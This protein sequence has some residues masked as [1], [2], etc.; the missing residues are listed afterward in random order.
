MPWSV[1]ICL[2][3]FIRYFVPKTAS[4]TFSASTPVVSLSP[5]FERILQSFFCLDALEQRVVSVLQC[6]EK[7][8]P[9]LEDVVPNRV[10]EGFPCGIHSH[11]INKRPRDIL[12]EKVVGFPS[13]QVDVE[14]E[15]ERAGREDLVLI[16]LG[17]R[18]IQ[19]LSR[20]CLAALKCYALNRALGLHSSECIFCVYRMQSFLH[21]HRVLIAE[22]I[23][24]NWKYKST[25][26]YFTMAEGGRLENPAY[27]PDDPEVPG[28]DDDDNENNQDYDETSPFWPGSASTPGPGG[29]E[30][31]MQTMHHEKGGLPD[32]SYDEISSLGS[33]VHQD[34]NQRCLKEQKNS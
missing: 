4:R 20:V 29:E 25:K 24:F 17:H 3:S 6:K 10:L 15:R 2:S 19:G 27:D 14:D 28:N 33:F 11:L 1:S 18:N 8:L 12:H 22:I 13:S 32:T 30:I 31:P 21:S 34:D 23:F 5:A 9:D 16:Q 7:V 26:N